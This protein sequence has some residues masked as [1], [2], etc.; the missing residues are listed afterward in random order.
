MEVDQTMDD[1][2]T[3]AGGDR[4]EVEQNGSSG[5]SGVEVEAAK[6]RAKRKVKVDWQCLNARCPNT[7]GGA[8]GP[9][10]SEL[11]TAGDFHREYFGAVKKEGDDKDR[12][13]KVCL[14]CDADSKASLRDIS[15]NISVG[16]PAF[17]D[18]G[19]FMVSWFYFSSYFVNCLYYDVCCFLRRRR[20]TW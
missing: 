8:A 5:S 6:K 9:D 13:M 17:Q 3:D 14:D 10:R 12:K 20:W 1:A 7:R 15:A 2:V 19:A 4:M 18:I 16:R 11:V